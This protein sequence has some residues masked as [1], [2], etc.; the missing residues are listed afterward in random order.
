MMKQLLYVCFLIISFSSCQYPWGHHHR[1][2]VIEEI[3]SNYKFMYPSGEV[4]VLSIREDSTYKRVLY[5]KES[6]Y[7][8]KNSPGLV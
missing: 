4:E 3:N 2:D 8:R 5:K 1:S 7:L 6:H